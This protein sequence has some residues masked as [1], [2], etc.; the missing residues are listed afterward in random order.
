[1]EKY[2]EYYLVDVLHSI[3]RKYYVDKIPPGIIFVHVIIIISYNHLIMLG[4]FMNPFND[5]IVP[6][7]TYE[8]FWLKIILSE[9]DV[10]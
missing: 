8:Y 1:M 10:L 5:R 9:G 4:G 7:V 3:V 6:G 2:R